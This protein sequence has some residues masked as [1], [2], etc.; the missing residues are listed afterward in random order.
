M[1]DYGVELYGDAIMV[2]SS[3]AEAKPDAVRAL[4]RAYVKALKETVRDPAAAIEAVLR[5]E[6]TANKNTEL[7]RLHM[8]IHDNIVTPGVKINGYGA[9]DAERFVAA[10]DQIALTH[11]FK[12][13]DKATGAFDPSF[14]PPA[15]ERS[16]SDTASR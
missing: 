11:R 10:L 6:D 4:L 1:A 16:V 12:A 5:R 8:A 7:D 3:F 14:L 9:V 15:V 13:K 2:A